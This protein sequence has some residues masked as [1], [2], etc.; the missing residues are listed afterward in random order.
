MLIPFKSGTTSGTTTATNVN[1]VV[2]NTQGCGPQG[3]LVALIQNQSGSNTMYYTIL[4]YPF[5]SGASAGQAVTIK[6]Q[7]SIAA[8][9]TVTSTDV[10]KNYAA[11]VIQVQNS[12]GACA[13]QID[14]ETY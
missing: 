1:A 5:D 3:K 4:G 9:T 11:V 7:T 13:Y 14:W 6:A 2:V 12:S 8:N 10:D